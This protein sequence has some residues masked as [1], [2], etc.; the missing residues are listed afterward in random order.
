MQ[1]PTC[2]LPTHKLSPIEMWN[3]NKRL[4]TLVADVAQD[5]ITIRS[6]DWVRAWE[7]RSAA[8]AWLVVGGMAGV[9][10][11]VGTLQGGHCLPRRLQYVQDRDRFDIEFSLVEVRCPGASCSAGVVFAE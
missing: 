8:A 7:L 9:D 2:E 4:Q 1:G 6:L 10:P 11:E 3:G 5:T